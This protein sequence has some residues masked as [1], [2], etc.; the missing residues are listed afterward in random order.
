[1]VLQIGQLN[2]YFF[3]IFIYFLAVYLSI[4][5]VDCMFPFALEGRTAIASAETGLSLCWVNSGLLLTLVALTARALHLFSYL[6][7][8]YIFCLIPSSSLEN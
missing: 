6:S 1:M 8:N 4:F 2:S 7:K 5:L 3:L